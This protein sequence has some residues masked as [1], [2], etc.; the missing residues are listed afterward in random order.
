M[1]KG[2]SSHSVAKVAH[3]GK[4]H[5]DPRLVG[6]GD[7]L[8]VAQRPA[9]LNHRRGARLDRCV[10]RVGERQLTIE[11]PFDNY[12]FS[13]FSERCV[14]ALEKRIAAMRAESRRLT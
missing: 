5:R 6:T 3:P 12:V 8:V 4:D 11:R 10:E 7:D 9:G 1:A 13:D 14:D 2:G